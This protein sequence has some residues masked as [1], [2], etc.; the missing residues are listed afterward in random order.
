MGNEILMV[1]YLM[2]VVSGEGTKSLVWSRDLT[3][4]LLPERLIRNN[5]CGFFDFIYSN[6]NLKILT[7]NF[8]I[9]TLIFV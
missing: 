6:L 3:K 9:A 5:V 8:H 1:F 4:Q 7:N 2:V